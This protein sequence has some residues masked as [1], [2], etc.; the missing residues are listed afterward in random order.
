MVV[1]W[2]VK[3]VSSEP[4][5]SSVHC[6]PAHWPTTKHKQLVEWA[7]RV[8]LS[9]LLGDDVFAGAQEARQRLM[10]GLDLALFLLVVRQ[11]ET[12]RTWQKKT[13]VSGQPGRARLLISR[14]C[15]LTIHDY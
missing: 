15:F 14:I 10:E 11:L 12:A 9:R 8:S 3:A 4:R 7:Y 6:Q 1:T 2:A 5:H 13:D